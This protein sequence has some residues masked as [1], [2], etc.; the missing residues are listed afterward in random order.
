[1]YNTALLETRPSDTLGYV[2]RVPYASAAERTL[3][4]PAAALRTQAT[5]TG[6]SPMRGRSRAT[7]EVKALANAWFEATAHLS[8]VSRYKSHPNFNKLLE[9]GWTAATFAVD[10]LRSGNIQMH[11]LLLLKT[12]TDFDPVP[13]EHVGRPTLM[14]EDWLSAIE[15]RGLIL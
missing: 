2:P 5:P 13:V 7:V 14:A 15:Q 9:F 1:M 8:Q 3:E 6:L 4:L 10:Q 11:W 12:L